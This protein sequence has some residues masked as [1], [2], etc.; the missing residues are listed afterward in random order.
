MNI[1]F[2]GW[3]VKCYLNLCLAVQQL[4]AT[5]TLS[6]RN[7]QL[8]EVF[9]A[10]GTFKL[11]PAAAFGQPRSAPVRLLAQDHVGQGRQIR[12]GKGMG[13]SRHHYH[14]TC[15]FCTLD[16]LSSQPHHHQ[17]PPTLPCSCS[18]MA[19]HVH[20]VAQYSSD[21]LY[22]SVSDVYQCTMTIKYFFQPTSHPSPTPYIGLP[23][24]AHLYVF[25]DT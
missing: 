17:V 24:R 22:T 20:S 19:A 9:L 14:W 25:A 15:C 11:V 12:L 2:S 13:F 4:R 7:M 16:P 18:C 5:T 8:L 1:H 10:N 6:H 23:T 21:Q 3:A